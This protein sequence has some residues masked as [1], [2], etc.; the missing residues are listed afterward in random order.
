MIF[1]KIPRIVQNITFC[2]RSPRNERRKC[3]SSI[4]SYMKDLELDVAKN[5]KLTVLCDDGH[6]ELKPQ[7]SCFYRCEHCYNLQEADSF[8]QNGLWIFMEECAYCVQRAIDM[9]GYYEH[10]IVPNFQ[11]NATMKTRKRMGGKDIFYALEQ[12]AK[13]IAESSTEPEFSEE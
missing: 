1:F 2:Q 7:R 6:Y 8:E 12:G 10:G 5:E 9:L 3:R 11:P 13:I 4:S